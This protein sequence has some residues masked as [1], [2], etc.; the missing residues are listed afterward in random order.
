[1]GD[2][3][4]L[5]QQ[6]E[7]AA[8]A[9]A[10]AAYPAAV[11]ARGGAKLLALDRWV[12][13]E[14]PAA[15]RAREPR[16]LTHD[17]LLRVVRWKMGRGVWR[18][19][20]LQLATSNAVE[21][22]ETLTAEALAA[23]EALPLPALEPAAGAGLETRVHAQEPGNATPAPTSSTAPAPAPK[24]L[25]A[26]VRALAKLRGIGPATVSAVLAA[27]LPERYP[28]LEDVI[29]AQ[30]PTLGPPAFTPRYYAA[31][32]EALRARAATLAARCPAGGW[33]PHAVDLALWA[34]A[35]PFLTD[36]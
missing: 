13:D 28:F 4:A 30:V 22:V 11:E 31:Y 35:A 17:E 21:A 29:A 18:A 19:N 33:T 25:L 2:S 34:T 3:T 16:H 6:D 10:L 1:M 36:K 15:V 24:E 5:W 7:C 9:A 14:L 20:N 32:A 26:P 8:W 23:A 27:V 12:H